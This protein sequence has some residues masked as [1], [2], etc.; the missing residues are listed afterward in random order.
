MLRGSILQF[1]R[2]ALSYHLFLR[3][4]FY[5]FLSGRLRQVW[6]YSQRPKGSLEE[7][8]GETQS[9]QVAYN[10]LFV[11]QSLLHVWVKLRAAYM[12]RAQAIDLATVPS[13]K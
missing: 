6:L 5:L 13:N 11:H 3:P 2:P 1:F 4:S 10:L 8:K 7:I 12:Q 9:F